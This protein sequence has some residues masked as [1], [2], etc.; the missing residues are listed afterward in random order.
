MYKNEY[1]EI[2]E[3]VVK[4]LQLEA[5]IYKFKREL[6]NMEQILL[7]AYDIQIKLNHPSSKSNILPSVRTLH[8]L[9]LYFLGKWLMWCIR[10][11]MTR[12]T[13]FALI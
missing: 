8:Q 10:F 5:L 3:Q 7:E 4:C 12:L 9:A 6:D 11:K 2:S 1:G 13:Y